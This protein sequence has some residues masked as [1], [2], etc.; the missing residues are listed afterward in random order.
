DS[1]ELYYWGI[2]ISTHYCNNGFYD[3]AILFLERGVRYFE[4]N[5][6]DNFQ[7]KNVFASAYEYLGSAYAAQKRYPEAEEKYNKCIQLKAIY[8]P[9][10]TVNQHIYPLLSWAKIQLEQG[11]LKEAGYTIE[12]MQRLWKI[13]GNEDDFDFSRFPDPGRVADVYLY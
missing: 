3:S 5:E 11:K 2:Q 6:P 9:E 8:S 1:K 4:K 13:S 7:E 10:D 12:R